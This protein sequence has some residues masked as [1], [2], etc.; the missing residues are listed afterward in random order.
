[1]KTSVPII[2]ASGSPR[3]KEL[4]QA[5]GFNFQIEFRSVDETYPANL[6]LH[7]VPTYLATKKIN[8]FEKEFLDN[9][10]VITAD[11]IVI[12]EHKI[13][14]KPENQVEAINML[15]ALSG[16][17]HTVVTGVCI[18]ANHEIHLFD[19]T[20]QVTFNEL[21]K[22]EI[23]DYVN[24]FEPYDKA[25]SY[26]IQEWIGYAAVKKIEGCF[27][28]VMGLPTSA[29]YQTLKKIIKPL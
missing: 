23:E 11:T 28:N 25:G 3:R 14:G 16:K 8:A 7:E 20:T 5:L 24:T 6:P 21:S 19:N 2:L 17:T 22:N 18:A 4:L 26:G 15:I 29:L 12:S 10:I 27:F 1:M 13:L 9:K